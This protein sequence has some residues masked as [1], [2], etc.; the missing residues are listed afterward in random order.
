MGAVVITDGLDT[1]HPTFGDS[2][3]KGGPQ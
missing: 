2:D 3:D 1:G